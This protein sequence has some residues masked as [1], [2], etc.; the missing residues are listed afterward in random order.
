MDSSQRTFCGERACFVY[1]VHVESEQLSRCGYG[2]HGII[3]EIELEKFDWD[4]IDKGPIQMNS[5]ELFADGDG[6]IWLR[7]RS[8]RK[9]ANNAVR[10]RENNLKWLRD[11]LFTKVVLHVDQRALVRGLGE[12]GRREKAH[13]LAVLAPGDGLHAVVATWLRFSPRLG[14]RFGVGGRWRRV[15]LTLV[16][17]LVLLALGC[18]TRPLHEHAVI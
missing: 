11:Y 7:E 10:R 18:S 1:V 8:R 2:K 13:A 3:T 4:D 12:S 17:M 16:A 5:G 14:A 6:I 9:A 15:S